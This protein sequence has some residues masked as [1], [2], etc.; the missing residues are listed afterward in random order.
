[1]KIKIGITGQSG[2]V[3]SHLYQQLSKFND[4]Y[5]IIDFDKTYFMDG[6]KLRTFVKSCDVIVHLAAMMRSPVEGEVYNT[7]MILVNKLL[8]AIEAENITPDLFFASSIQ[9]N[10]GSEYGRCKLEGKRILS[11]WARKHHSGFGCFILPNLFGPLAKPNS[12]SFIATFSFKLNHD[13]HPT[14]LIDN[15][16][17]LKYISTTIIEMVSFISEVIKKKNINQKVFQPDYE[18]KVSE[19]LSI[20]ESFK[21]SER[22]GININL[23]SQA[24]KDLYET[25]LSY[26]D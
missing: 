2:F 20:L 9:E 11:E 26:K 13:E 25:Y 7:N 19:V 24:E 1:M 4:S 3:G 6:L 10:N 21:D 5:E 8:S 14:I 15:K 23:K 12:H 22:K 17:K 18:L 16:I